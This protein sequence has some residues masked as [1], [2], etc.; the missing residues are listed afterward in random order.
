MFG[1]QAAESLKMMAPIVFMI[2][3]FYFLLIRPQQKKEKERVAMI[4]NL[5]NGDK[6][7]TTSGIYGVVAGI[8]DDVVTLK[9]AS[10][11]NIEI[12]KSAVQAKIS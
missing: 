10:S 9:I 5:K 7:I 11:T 2:I 6:I 4:S 12:L 8:K 3:I 1:S